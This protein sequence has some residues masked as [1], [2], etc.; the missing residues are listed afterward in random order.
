MHVATLEANVRD[1]DRPWAVE[2]YLP[3]G[4]LLRGLDAGDE[5]AVSAGLDG[6]V[7][8]HR[9]R[10]ASA[11]DADAVQ[12]AVAT[13]ATAML[14]LARREGMAVTVDHELIPDALNDPEHYPAGE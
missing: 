5:S 8:F 11:R 12:Q 4:R 13:D 10:V 2:R 7:E 6:L 3:Y 9:D 14:A 1:R